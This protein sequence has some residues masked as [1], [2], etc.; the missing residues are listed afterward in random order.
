M[1]D[2]DVS[3][4][5]AD[6]SAE[7][8]SLL[9]SALAH[10][11]P[12]DSMFMVPFVLERV[13]QDQQ[14]S[15]VRHLSRLRTLC[16]GGANVSEDVFTWLQTRRVPVVNLFGQTEM[17]GVVARRG[18]HG[19]DGSELADG[20]MGV[21]VKSRAEDDEGE[22]VILSKVRLFY[23][24]RCIPCPHRASFNTFPTNT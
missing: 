21:L 16:V 8:S 9:M 12:I 3:S 22:L 4:P 20:L 5:D 13:Y 7:L 19:V 17:C 24:A 18:Y 10:H 23:Y 11:E 14:E 1:Y 6:A 2:R 15:Y